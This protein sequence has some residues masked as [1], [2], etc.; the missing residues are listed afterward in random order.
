MFE[1]EAW[2]IIDS[3]KLDQFPPLMDITFKYRKV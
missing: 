3:E 1:L 2:H